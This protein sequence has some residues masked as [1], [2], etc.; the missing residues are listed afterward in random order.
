VFK[1][2]GVRLILTISAVALSEGSP[3]LTEVA[4]NSVESLSTPVGNPKFKELFGVNIGEYTRREWQRQLP[5]ILLQSEHPL[6]R[7]LIQ[8]MVDINP[9]V[10][11]LEAYNVFLEHRVQLIEEYSPQ[12]EDLILTAISLR[13][14]RNMTVLSIGAADLLEDL[15]TLSGFLSAFRCQT[16]L[17]T[18]SDSLHDLAFNLFKQTLVQ[19]VPDIMNE[20][21]RASLLWSAQITEAFA[22]VLDHFFISLSTIDCYTSEDYLGDFINV[23][24]RTI[25]DI[26]QAMGSL[27]MYSE[28]KEVR[29]YAKFV[30]SFKDSMAVLPEF[31]VPG[32]CRPGLLGR[33]SSI[34]REFSSI[35]TDVGL[36]ALFRDIGLSFRLDLLP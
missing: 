36:D 14:E 26:A 18:A 2:K 1:M 8:E 4:D 9:C 23:G 5:K 32:D 30:S 11:S 6:F 19:D 12:I 21:V 17:Q 31:K 28:A 29:Q 20:G 13:G 15:N 25:N 16:D 22:S 7:D 10:D 27:G 33:F 3:F 35:I 24:S 34:L